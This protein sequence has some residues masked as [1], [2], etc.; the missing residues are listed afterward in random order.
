MAPRI[1][2]VG[3][4]YLGATHAVCMAELGFDV[5]GVDVDEA[6]VAALQEAKSPFYEP[7]LDPM[8]RKH[9][10]SGRLRFTSS[11][12]ECAE[13]GDV[14]FLCVST[15]QRD[16]ELAADLSHVDQAVSSL[17]RRLTRPCVIAGKST[18][19][20]GTAERLTDLVH[21][22]APAG[23][24]VV[25]AW[26]PEFLREGFAIEDTLSPGR[27]VFGLPDDVSAAHTAQEM[28]G[29]VYAESIAAD[30]PVVLADLATAQL[31]KSA[32]NAFLATKIS[33][34][35]AMAELCEATGGDVTV[36]ADAIG[37]DP[38]IGRSFLNAGLGF[39]G[40]CLP[41]DIRGFMARAGELGAGDALTFLRE[42]DAIN[43]RRRARVVDLAAE[44]LDRPWAGAKVAV[45]GA[46]FKPESDDIRDSP[47][48]N[49]AGRLHLFG[50][51]VSVYD[52]RAMENAQR[53]WPT[54]HYAESV[55]DACRGAHLV[56]VLTEWA[57][58]RE[59]D[60]EMLAGVVARPAVMDGRNCLDPGVW[61]AAGWTYRALGRP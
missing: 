16:G 5:L 13:F 33:F 61:R 34:I 48:L 56:L 21:S 23:T 54:L 25:L 11:Y 22:L 27:L 60:P 47:A 14:H 15:P 7:G 2:V 20:V 24:D 38:R 36:L 49:V 8:L 10:E 50:A 6:K 19:P 37:Y 44:L 52:P 39:G 26:N 59:V 18:V 32:A 12:D 58:F 28:L 4:G 40:G 51:H 29:E 9:V 17:A 31:T 41:K 55:F 53:S 1:T 43:Q 30:T 57:H 35:N 3:C 42:V 46:A 45:L